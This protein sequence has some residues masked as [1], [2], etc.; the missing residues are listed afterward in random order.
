ME[1]GA[2][3]GWQIERAE[4]RRRRG[5]LGWW[6]VKMVGAMW[7]AVEEVRSGRWLKYEQTLAT[8]QWLTTAGHAML[9]R[10][11]GPCGVLSSTHFP[12]VVP[13]VDWAQSLSSII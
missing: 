2:G 3:G 1:L 8:R 5:W 6:E 13:R 7:S 4:Q 11:P 9:G 12:R 10:C